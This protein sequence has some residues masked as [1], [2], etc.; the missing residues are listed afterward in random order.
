[1]KDTDKIT[2]TFGQLA[3][4]VNE[5]KQQKQLNE[6]S[7]YEFGYVYLNDIF[8][9]PLENI[10]QRELKKVFRNRNGES[11]ELNEAVKSWMKE[12]INLP[13]NRWLTSVDISNFNGVVWD[14]NGGERGY[15]LAP[16]LR[17]KV[18]ESAEQCASLLSSY[19]RKSSSWGKTRNWIGRTYP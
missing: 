12:M 13:K 19:G 10:P 4:L 5:S 6:A 3:R 16:A 7:R 1:M 17:F 8:F 18:Y 11:E 15:G 2:L 9:K 14:T